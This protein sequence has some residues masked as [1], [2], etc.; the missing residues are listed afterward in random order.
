MSS[1]TVTWQ[2]ED[3]TEL[4][5]DTDVEKGTIPHYDGEIL[6]KPFDEDYVDVLSGWTDGTNTYTENLPAVNGDVTYTAVYDR[7]AIIHE[8][9]VFVNSTES[10]PEIVVTAP[11]TGAVLTAGTDYTIEIGESTVTV[12]GIGSYTGEVQKPY[13]VLHREMK[14]SVTNRRKAGNNA[15]ATLS[16]EWYLPKNATNIQAGI[17]RLSTDDTAVTN[18]DVYKNGVKKASALKTT[19]GKYS[20]SLLMNSTHANQNLYTVTYVTYEIDGVPF[21]SISK[22][23]TGYPNPA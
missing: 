23:F 20:F 2:N 8:D 22:A 16:G 9:D 15:K 7:F 12:K 13:T 5:K 14:S 3:G 18:Y 19:S 10:T 11:Q 1:Y 6:Q 4:E 21:V 17:A